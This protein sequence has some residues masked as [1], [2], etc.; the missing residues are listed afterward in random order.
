MSAWQIPLTKGI[1][2]HILRARAFHDMA[3]TQKK[4][5]TIWSICDNTWWKSFFINYSP[6]LATFDFHRHLRWEF[7]TTSGRQFL[8]QK[9]WTN[10]EKYCQQTGKNITTIFPF[11][12][13]SKWHIYIPFSILKAWPFWMLLGNGRFSHWSSF[14]LTLES[15]WRDDQLTVS[16]PCTPSTQ[17]L[18]LREQVRWDLPHWK[19][20]NK[21]N[22][23]TCDLYRI[24]VK[25]T[26]YITK[27]GLL[28]YCFSVALFNT[29]TNYGFIFT[30][31]H[32]IHSF[33]KWNARNT[34]QEKLHDA[35]AWAIVCWNLNSSFNLL[36]WN[37]V[38]GIWSFARNT[39]NKKQWVFE[40]AW[41]TARSKVI[42]CFSQF[43]RS[44]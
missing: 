8:R 27:K 34:L 25:R 40:K 44:F 22:I 1:L 42:I 26:Y 29:L 37:A 7:F 23:K 3:A 20:I 30:C 32:Y 4:Q 13:K 28:S 17:P 16:L 5:Y 18:T 6:F 38:F 31:P 33:I 39:N 24:L 9:I 36:T 14:L 35:M 11:C 10:F 43:E 12:V 19:W 41:F 15:P 2:N 21:M